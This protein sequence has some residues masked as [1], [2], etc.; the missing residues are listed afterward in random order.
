MRYHI[1]RTTI[2]FGKFVGI[3]CN[4]VGAEQLLMISLSILSAA[5]RHSHSLFFLVS[6]DRLD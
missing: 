4:D 1:D 3:N 5:H 2:P 6:C